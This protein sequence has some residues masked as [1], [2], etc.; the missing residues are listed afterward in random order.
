MPPITIT[1]VGGLK[2]DEL[3]NQRVSQEFVGSPTMLDRLRSCAFSEEYSQKDRF[4]ASPMHKYYVVWCKGDPEC[5]LKVKLCDYTEPDNSVI[6]KAGL[7]LGRIASGPTHQGWQYLKVFIE[8]ITVSQGPFLVV[9]R[10]KS[11]GGRKAFEDFE[12]IIRCR[13][14]PYNVLI[15]GSTLS[16]TTGYVS[17][18]RP[19]LERIRSM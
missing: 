15:V 7:S 10:L 6:K 18:H 5:L 13:A 2:L 14:M 16:S 11:K 3:M 12:R 1:E 17:N 9:A 19:T 8:C 4:V